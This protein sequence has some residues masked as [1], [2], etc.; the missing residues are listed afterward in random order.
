MLLRISGPKV[1]DI[2]STRF[3]DL[4][5]DRGAW[6]AVMAFET[7]AELPVLVIRAYAPATYT[8]EDTLEI[9]LSGNMHLGNRV[10]QAIAID[11][12]IRP[13]RPGEFTARAYLNGRLSIIEAEGVAATIAAV[14]QRDLV[15]AYQLRAGVLAAEYDALH[16]RLADLLA[17]VEAGVDFSDQEDVRPISPH[18]LLAA[19]RSVAKTV[20]QALSRRVSGRFDRTVPFV[21]LAGPPNAGKSTL[22]NALLGHRRVVTSPVRGTTRDAII[23]PVTWLTR[24]GGDHIDIRLADLPGLDVQAGSPAHIAAQHAAL[25]TLES[26]D[27]ILWCSASGRDLPPAEIGNRHLV[28]VRTKCDRPSAVPMQSR[29]VAVCAIDGRGLDE[30]R[31]AVSAAIAEGEDIGADD[32]FLLPRHAHALRAAHSAL[33]QAIAAFDASIDADPAMIAESLRT[34]IRHLGE[35]TGRT[36]TDDI[37]GR[38]FSRFCIGK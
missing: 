16:D 12:S 22:F 26:A 29:E 10:M 2:A 31:A 1:Q 34:A 25:R 36:H 33:E 21:V 14:T 13:A 5:D 19:V 38:I 7:G 15:R 32:A 3:R 35:L 17:L 4:P 18:D 11:P 8:G 9:L 30:L 23:E 27:L 28:Y 20:E 6:P 37:L 24:T